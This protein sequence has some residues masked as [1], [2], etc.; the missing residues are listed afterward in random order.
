MILL[1]TLN[2]AMELITSNDSFDAYKTDF[3]YQINEKKNSAK[4]MSLITI[5]I[6]ALFVGISFIDLLSLSD[7]EWIHLVFHGVLLYGGIMLLAVGII[8]FIAKGVMGGEPISTFNSE[9]KEFTSRG[10]IT[11]FSHMIDI[12]VQS[13]EV[14]GK[15]LTVILY[16]RNGK[17]RGLV[18]GTLMMKDT[19]G[20]QA[21]V[22]DLNDMI[23]DETTS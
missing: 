14:M 22:K 6:G 18:P 8:L 16:K 3:G 1:W 9:T 7:W 10:K 15:N 12:T 13:N 21:F 23:Q 11:P 5:V 4:K 17:K 19:S 20:L 2:Y